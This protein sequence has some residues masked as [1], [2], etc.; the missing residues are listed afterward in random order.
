MNVIVQS[1]LKTL[2]KSQV[3]LDNLSNPELCNATVSPYYSSIGAQDY[4]NLIIGG[5]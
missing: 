2:Q 3:L 1:T 4:L 5:I